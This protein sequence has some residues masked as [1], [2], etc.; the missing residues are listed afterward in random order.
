MQPPRFRFGGLDGFHETIKDAFAANPQAL[1]KF[2]V[3]EIDYRVT[4]LDDA[5]MLN[6]HDEEEVKDY[7]AWLKGNGASGEF[8]LQILL[9]DTPTTRKEWAKRHVDAQAIA[10]SIVD[11]PDMMLQEFHPIIEIWSEA[12][13]AGLGVDDVATLCHACG[14]PQAAVAPCPHCL[15]PSA[16]PRRWYPL[17]R[18]LTTE[19]VVVVNATLATIA[20]QLSIDVYGCVPYQAPPADI[21]SLT[22]MLFDRGAGLDVAYLPDHLEVFHKEPTTRQEIAARMSV[23]H[24]IPTAQNPNPLG[25]LLPDGA[26]T[27]FDL[28][29]GRAFDD[30]TDVMSTLSKLATSDKEMT[31]EDALAFEKAVHQLVGQP[32]SDA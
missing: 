18:R 11:M 10:E 32:K 16:P 9:A 2:V 8:P 23:M 25:S 30:A 15:A 5:L 20:P 12:N 31:M 19:E 3:A 13:Q 4:E 6:H 26:P 21:L 29:K 7:L 14:E 24:A 27:A 22:R 1:A 17:C 28:P